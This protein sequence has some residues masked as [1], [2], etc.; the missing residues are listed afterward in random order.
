LS[1]EILAGLFPDLEL[2]AGT[3]Q[4]KPADKPDSNFNIWPN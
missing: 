1:I 2:K 4:L 3:N